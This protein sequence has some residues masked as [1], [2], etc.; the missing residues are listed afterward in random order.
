[1]SLLNSFHM[2]DQ[3]THTRAPGWPM[4]SELVKNGAWLAVIH[5]FLV[6]TLRV[7]K[8]IFFSDTRHA[9]GPY[10]RVSGGAYM[11]NTCR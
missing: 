11:L 10:E 7:P 5:Y 2:R 3:W 1:M 8:D 6:L 4:A 9:N